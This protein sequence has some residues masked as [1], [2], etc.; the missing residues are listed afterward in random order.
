MET[1]PRLTAAAEALEMG[2][3]ELAREILADLLAEVAPI[4]HGFPCPVCST[5]FEWPGLLDAHLARSGHGLR[6]VA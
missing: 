6:K 2:D 3:V 1:V 5:R 4:R